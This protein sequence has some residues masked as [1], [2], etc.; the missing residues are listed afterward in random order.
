MRFL[1]LIKLAWFMCVGVN[2]RIVSVTHFSIP[3]YSR[4]LLYATFCLFT[5]TDT[6]FYMSVLQN[7][8]SQSCYS[9]CTGMWHPQKATYSADICDSNLRFDSNK[10]LHSSC[11]KLNCNVKY[12]QSTPNVDPPS[13]STHETL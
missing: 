12:I 13:L 3:V 7:L 10:T 5:G 8:S 1:T 11:A 6:S 2:T 9:V 4:H